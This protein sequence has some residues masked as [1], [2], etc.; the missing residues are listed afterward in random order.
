MQSRHVPAAG[1]RYWVALLIAS[2][3]GANAGDVIAKFFHLGHVEGLPVLAV[4]LALI[5]FAERRDG[6]GHEIYYWAAVVV[7]R[8]AAMNLGDFAASSFRLGRPG[9]IADLAVLLVFFLIFTPS[10]KS[11]QSARTWPFRLPAT[12]TRHWATLLIAGMLGT[13]LGDYV[14]FATGLG[15]LY[16]AGLEGGTLAALLFVGRTG[17]L[18]D[19]W[20]YWLAV[21]AVQAA[22]TS[23]S[24]FLAHAVFGLPLS[25]LATGMVLVVTLLLWR[26]RSPEPASAGSP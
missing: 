8:T 10:T 15:P 20:F 2:V 22:G 1:G 16:A 11:D 14:S 25:T 5:L 26:E 7:I 4:L 6:R 17:P 23:F 3:F 19:V 9:L 24:D 12:D 21:V 13:V 18:A